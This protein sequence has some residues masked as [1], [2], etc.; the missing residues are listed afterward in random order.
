LGDANSLA[1]ALLCCTFRGC[2]TIKWIIGSGEKAF[3]QERHSVC[4]GSV[5]H[6]EAFGG[7]RRRGF[8]SRRT[9]NHR[10]RRPSRP[11][12]LGRLTDLGAWLSANALLRSRLCQHRK[13]SRDRQVRSCERIAEIAGLT[14]ESVLIMDVPRWRAAE[15][16]QVTGNPEEVPYSTNLGNNVLSRMRRVISSAVRYLSPSR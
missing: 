14:D 1:K 10:K 7:D 2:G 6:A 12:V 15:A 16:A 5:W 3:T 4:S 8:H 13:R 9:K 11:I